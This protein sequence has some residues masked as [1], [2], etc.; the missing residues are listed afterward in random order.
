MSFVSIR[1]EVFSELRFP[2]AVKSLVAFVLL[3]PLLWLSTRPSGSHVA[4][5]GALAGEIMVTGGTLALAVLA[6]I[7]PFVLLVRPSSALA[8]TYSWMALAI[9]AAIWRCGRPGTGAKRRCDT[10]FTTCWLPG[11]HGQAL[12]P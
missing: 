9:V 2:G 7:V 5:I 11:S 3:V 4:G 10:T 1:T 8:L 6:I 12:R